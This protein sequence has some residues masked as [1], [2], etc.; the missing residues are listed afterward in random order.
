MQAYRN[1]KN[2]INR[3]NDWLKRDYFSRKFTGMM[4]I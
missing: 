2:Q 1:P 3:E 4:V